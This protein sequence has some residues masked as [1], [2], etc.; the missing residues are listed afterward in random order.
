MNRKEGSHSNLLNAA[1]EKSRKVISNQISPIS[2]ATI[3][4]LLSLT[5]SDHI[6]LNITGLMGRIFAETICD[7]FLQL[8]R[9]DLEP[10][11]LSSK[12]SAL[13]VPL[14]KERPYI[15]SHLRL[16]QI[17]GNQVSHAGNPDL[18]HQDATSIIISI[19]RIVDFYENRLNR[20]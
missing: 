8:Y 7:E 10:S 2:L 13:S 15:E 12:I 16:L 18:N 5:N 6:S 19:I 14:R 1:I 20:Q 9:I 3:N 4:N 17:Y 11:T